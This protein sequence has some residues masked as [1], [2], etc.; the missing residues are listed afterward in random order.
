MTGVYYDPKDL[1]ALRIAAFA[2]ATEGPESPEGLKQLIHRPLSVSERGGRRQDIYAYRPADVSGTEMERVV[3]LWTQQEC[4][5]APIRRHRGP[6]CIPLQAYLDLVTGLDR[7]PVQWPENASGYRQSAADHAMYG[8]RSD[9]PAREAESDGP[10]TTAGWDDGK[11]LPAGWPPPD[12]PEEIDAYT[13]YELA[14]QHKG[15]AQT[16]YDRKAAPA[17]PEPKRFDPRSHTNLLSMLLILVF[18]SSGLMLNRGAQ[19]RW[20]LAPLCLL[21]YGLL[22]A[23]LLLSAIKP[24][25]PRAKR[26][27][28]LGAVALAAAVVAV[29]LLTA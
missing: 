5:N 26:L 11:A 7:L 6:G 4:D 28:I 2:G 20:L 22:A 15:E 25:T 19:P 13:L 18:L 24:K 10:D 8:G 16:P 3:L 29:L 14:H 27:T 21:L 17:Q 9:W 23:W 1:E 12:P